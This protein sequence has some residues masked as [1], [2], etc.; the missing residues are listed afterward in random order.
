M[1]G[2]QGQGLSQ[3]SIPQQIAGQAQLPP[4]GAQAQLPASV[5]RMPGGFGIS[6]QL[7]AMIAKLQQRAPMA[8]PQAP[9]YPAYKPPVQPGMFDGG[10]GSNNFIQGR[11]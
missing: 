2:T 5:Q 10:P 1:A 7:L 4:M 8:Q 9:V 11:R 3:M 6:P